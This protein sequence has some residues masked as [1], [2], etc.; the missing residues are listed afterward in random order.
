M[1]LPQILPV[2]V[3]AIVAF[4]IGALWYSP[5]LFAKAWVRAHGHTPETLAAMQAG[6]ARAYGISFACFLLMAAVL[7]IFLTHL[8]V[9]GWMYGLHWGAMAWLGIAAPIGITANVY[10]DK[11]FMAWVIDG[12]YQLVYLMAMGAI[13]GAWR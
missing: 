8:G 5:A 12:G 10:S 11:P 1:I 6:A 4:L 7:A 3:A 2:V 13:L 9:M